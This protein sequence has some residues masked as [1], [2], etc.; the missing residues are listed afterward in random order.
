MFVLYMYYDNTTFLAMYNAST[1]EFLKAPFKNH[2]L[3]YK[4]L[5]DYILIWGKLWPNG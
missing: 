1:M 4:V 2:K 3:Q 5:Y